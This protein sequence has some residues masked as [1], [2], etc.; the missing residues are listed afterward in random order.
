MRG[1]MPPPHVVI[2]G[3]PK[4]ELG[5]APCAPENLEIPGSM[6][7]HR[8]GMTALNTVFNY[9]SASPRRGTRKPRPA[10][11]EGPRRWP[12]FRCRA[13]PSAP[14]PCRHGPRRRHRGLV[15]AIARQQLGEDTAGMGGLLAAE[16]VER[17]VLR[18]LQPAFRIPRRLAMADVVDHGRRHRAIRLFLAQRSEMSGV[19]GRFMPT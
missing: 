15:A 19:S 16:I 1:Q 4:G 12:A 6:L 11:S 8:P 3:R 2:P 17:N 14:A 7:S 18:A 10:R 13:P 9:T 5:C